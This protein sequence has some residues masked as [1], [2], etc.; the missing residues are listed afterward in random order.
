MTFTLTLI[1]RHGIWQ[2][3]DMRLTAHSSGDLVDD[4]SRK[5]VGFRCTDGDALMT[6]SGHGRVA[7]GAE[8]VDI[9]D[10]V[11]EFLRGEMQ[12]VAQTLDHIRQRATED[13]GTILVIRKHM[14]VVGAFLR[15]APW[16]VEIRNFVVTAERNTGPPQREFRM[17]PKV[18]QPP[19]ASA[20]IVPWPLIISAK[21]LSRLHKA[22]AAPNGPDD[23]K[24]FCDLL[25]AINLRVSRSYTKPSAHIALPTICRQS[26]CRTA[27][28]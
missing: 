11:R 21:D 25:A 6:Y 28:A 18:L 27:D 15:G 20:F 17:I 9:S 8:C 23:P 2:S 5:S 22:A 16:C 12:T 10:W 13:L 3:S 24:N 1:N 14:F 26:I 4:Y 7:A 19:T